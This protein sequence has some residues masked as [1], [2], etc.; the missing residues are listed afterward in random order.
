MKEISVKNGKELTSQ[1]S[2]L[3]TKSL[4]TK[5]LKSKNLQLKIIKKVQRKKLKNQVMT[6]L[7][8]IKMLLYP[9]KLRHLKHGV[10]KQ[11][12]KKDKNV[13]N[14]SDQ[15]IRQQLPICTLKYNNQ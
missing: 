12:M 10:K 6:C 5:R 2:T 3:M 14:S 1:S 9:K 7:N 15:N 13:F 4:F 11:F 8:K